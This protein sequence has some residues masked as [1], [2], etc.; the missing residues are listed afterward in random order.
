[1]DFASFISIVYAT[2]G[3]SVSK[4]KWVRIALDI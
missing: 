4:E 3:N 2:K 1:M